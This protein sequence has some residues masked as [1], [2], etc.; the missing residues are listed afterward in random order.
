MPDYEVIEINEESKKYFNFKNEL[1]KNKWFK[2]VY[3]RKMYAYVSDYVRIKTL[4]EHGGI[5]FDTDV[6]SLKSLDLFLKEKAFVGMQNNEED[7]DR[8]SLVEPAILGSC[9]GNSFLKQVLDFYD[10]SS[11]DNIWNKSFY[12][13][14]DIFKFLLEKSYEKQVYPSRAKQK[15]IKYKDI[16]IYPERFFIP[17]RYKENFSLKCL[18]PD[19]YTIHWFGGSWL[20][21]EILFF[22]KN[23]H[24]YSLSEIDEKQR[25]YQADLPGLDDESSNFSIAS[26]LRTK[27]L[28]KITFGSTRRKLKAQYEEQKRL[29]RMIKKKH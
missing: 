6:T 7:G 1:K 25:N 19:T 23:K 10:E 9:C 28:S 26:Y 14:P 24:I 13:M 11:S 17:F 3:D 2:A 18:T 22:L 16:S 29:Y 8:H 4:Y 21:P 5:Y 27:I 15:I 20:R 12:N